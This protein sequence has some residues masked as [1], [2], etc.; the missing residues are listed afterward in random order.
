MIIGGKPNCKEYYII[1]LKEK[2]LKG[3]LKKSDR[4]FTLKKNSIIDFNNQAEE[5][6]RILLKDTGDF[7]E[8]VII[9]EEK[10]AKLNYELVN[11]Q[12]QSK[13]D[14]F[15]AMGLNY[16]DSVKKF[17]KLL[18][19]DKTHIDNING[20]FFKWWISFN[21]AC[22]NNL[23]DFFSLLVEVENI[24]ELNLSD[25]TT[26]FKLESIKQEDFKEDAE[27]IEQSTGD[28]YQNNIEKD[29]DDEQKNSNETVEENTESSTSK[30]DDV[31][32]NSNE[33]LEKNAES[34][35]SK[36]DNINFNNRDELTQRINL[37]E[38]RLNSLSHLLFLLNINNN[39]LIVKTGSE[40]LDISKSNEIHESLAN[41]ILTYN[42]YLK[43]LESENE[44]LQKSLSDLTEELQQLNAYAIGLQNEI[45][46]LHDPKDI[47]MDNLNLVET[48]ENIFKKLL[49][50]SKVKLFEKVKNFDGGDGRN[51][52]ISLEEFVSD[53]LD[54]YKTAVTISN[55]NINLYYENSKNGEDTE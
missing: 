45:K 30:N 34:S 21:S 14:F 55:D 6:Y 42:K 26:D 51:Y 52:Q 12:S 40:L 25:I 5:T 39:K 18:S 41:K 27:H 28:E 4:T 38:D 35:T 13:N 22:D 20:K 8:C 43:K 33:T 2:E 9:L 3:R 1:F 23:D 16:T 10:E 15:T 50:M 37:L 31:L 44:I 54:A 48:R 53:V 19:S 46:L 32:K 47:S 24:P 36:N 11:S 17:K 29:Y 49:E 7:M